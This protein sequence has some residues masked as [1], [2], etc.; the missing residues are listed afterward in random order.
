[1]K[2]STLLMSLLLSLAPFTGQAAVKNGQPAPDFTLTDALTG[3]PFSLAA[4]KG[5][6]VVLEWVNYGCPFVKKFY[7]Q[8]DMQRLQKHAK[9]EG[10]IWVSINSG[11]KGKQGHFTSDAAAKD[12]FIAHKGE[13]SYYL[14]DESGDIGRRYGAKATP[15]M[16]VINDTGILVYQGAIDNTPSVKSSDIAGAENYVTAALTA[17]KSGTPIK[18]PRT[19]AYGCVVKY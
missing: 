13:A 3:K 16:F 17:L 7:Q 15:H 14:R 11:A 18:T 19:K 6:I 1:M 2:I 9:D 12:A 10:V 5:K 8:G 4:Q